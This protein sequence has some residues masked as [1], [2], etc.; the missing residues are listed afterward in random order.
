[1]I[2]SKVICVDI[3]SNKSWNIVA[4]GMFTLRRINQMEREMCNYLDWKL[5]VDNPI[6]GNFEA[7]QASWTERQYAMLSR[8]DTGY[9]TEDLGCPPRR[10][11][12]PSPT[13]RRITPDPKKS[14]VFKRVTL[15]SRPPGSERAHGEPA[16]TDE[17]YP[18]SSLR[19]FA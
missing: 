12:S 2:P 9:S 6:L 18:P 17:S 1:M 4:Q 11:Y 13:S 5:T 19:Y 8:W 3:Y 14:D 16:D 10:V 15:Q 7:T